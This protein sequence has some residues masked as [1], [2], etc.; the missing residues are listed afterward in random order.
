MESWDPH[1]GIAVRGRMILSGRV[2]TRI[3]EPT[4]ALTAGYAAPDKVDC[5]IVAQADRSSATSHLPL[6]LMKGD[7]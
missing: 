5:E 1:C 7:K 4:I 6:E 2:L 3:V